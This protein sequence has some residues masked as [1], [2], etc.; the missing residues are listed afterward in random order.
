MDDLDEFYGPNAGYVLELYERYQ[1]DPESVDPTTRAL[2]QGWSPPDL[3]PTNGIDAGRKGN[4]EAA[5]S[6]GQGEPAAPAS[7]QDVARVVGAAALAQAIREYG[8]LAARLDPLGAEPPGDPELDAATHG[9]RDWD[10]AQL[11]ASVVGGPAARGA[12]SALEAINALRRIYCDTTGYDY[13][14]IHDAEERAWLR[15]AAET[16]RF[17]IRRTTAQK[18]QLL[19]RLTQVEAFEQFLHRTFPG[20]KRFSIEGADMLIPMLDEAIRCQTQRGN[21]EVV[22]GMAHRGRLNVLAHVLEK[23][24]EVILHEFERADQRPSPAASETGSRGW[25]GDVKY[26]LGARWP[27]RGSVVQVSITLAPNPSH[28]EFVNP[29]VEGM[30]RAAQDQRSEPGPPRQD[31]EASLAVL[32]HG[33][34]AFPGEGIVAETLNLSRLE[35]YQTGGTI[36]IIVNNQ[37]GFTTEPSEGRSTL[38]AGDLAKGFEIPIIHVNADDPEACLAAARLACAYRDRFHKDFMIDLVGYRRWGHNEG[39]EPSFTQPRMY[40][41]IRSHPTVRQLWAQELERQRVIRP[42]E[43]DS[44]MQGALQR[45]EQARH[46]SAGIPQEE[47]EEPDGPGTVAARSSQLAARSSDTDEPRAASC[48]PRAGSEPTPESRYLTPEGLREL[49][50]AL[51][52]WPPGFTLNRRLER[53]LERRR[54]ALGP[55]GTIDWAH[56]E[57]LAFATILAEG[58]PIRLTGQDVERGTFSQRHLVL[59]DAVTGERFTPLQA[60][61]AARASFAVYNSPLSENAPLGFEYGYN[62]HSPTV[63]VLWEAQ[64]GDFVNA[65]QVI[66]DQFIVSARAKWRQSPGLVLLLPHGLEGQGPEHSSARLERLLQLA[67]GD[68]MSVVNSTTAA[69]YFHLLRRQAARLTPGPGW[70][71]RPLFVM[72]PKSLLRHPLAV[73]S[74]DELAGTQRSWVG[75]FQPVIDEGPPVETGDGRRETA[76]AIYQG[77]AVMPRQSAGALRVPSGARRAVTRLVLCSGKMAVDLAESPARPTASWVAVARVEELY[78]FPR[79]DLEEVLARY[80]GLQEVV[81]VQEEPENMGAWSYMSPRLWALVGPGIEVRSISRPRRSS[82]AVGSALR[83]AAEQASLIA[84]AF[85]GEGAPRGGRTE[86]LAAVTRD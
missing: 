32:I 66:V 1:R 67:A 15:D 80:P 70:A 10:L 28:L 59:H 23:P 65:G 60:L 3:A 12:P 75:K 79:V 24:Y 2:F 20:Q 34:A 47:E 19:E 6:T 46:V 48:E 31:L 74:V 27:G 42:E 21:R 83:H 72:S 62:V 26:H 69:Q 8:H 29:V 77:A 16:G 36:H 11:P 22:L 51:L 44:L 14:H 86:R 52:T 37:V 82:P 61:P 43:A 7:T 57:T 76:M 17:R 54:A 64:F 53:S 55:D 30:T 71:P 73:S 50:E 58:T 40:H 45:L 41:V 85:S 13:D 35:G 9:I 49:N 56:A 25:T 78:P 84:A 38:Y 5:V 18:R 81:W 63:M 39:D 68:N 4:E 33:D